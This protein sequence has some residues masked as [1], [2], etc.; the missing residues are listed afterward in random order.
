MRSALRSTVV[1]VG[2]TLAVMAAGFVG[3]CASK[4]AEPENIGVVRLELTAIPADVNCLRLTAQGARTVVQQFDVIPGTDASLL[5]TGLPTGLVTIT[6]DAFAASCATA[7]D[8][9]TANWVSEPQTLEVSSG[10]IADLSLVM[11]RNG[12]VRVGVDFKPDVAPT[13]TDGIQN[14]T[15]T[16][17]DCGGGTCPK[18]GGGQSCRTDQDCPPGQ[19]CAA[20][21][22]R[23]N[24]PTCT[25]GILNGDETDVDCGGGTC[26]KCGGGQSCRTD[27][28]CP[29]GQGCAAFTCRT[30]PPT[31]TDG[32][33][34]GDET[35]VDCGGGTCPKC[36]GGQSCRTD[37]DCPPGQGC[38]AFTCRT[39]PPTCTDGIQN[40]NET[41]VDCGGGTCPKCGGGQSC[42]TD[43]DCPA[44]QECSGGFSCRP[45]LTCAVPS[46]RRRLVERRGPLPRLDR[47]PR[48]PAVR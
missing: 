24:P 44:G 47:N 12:K 1:G 46:R 13:C 37:Q 2:L 39:N 15:E 17:V 9:T 43:Q 41:G 35:D 29:P 6:A 38:A 5:V 48:W 18:C 10:D 32:I 26:P 3:G 27:Q 23:I 45:V 33:Q 40:G 20:F 21:T 4:P 28:D 42:R 34:N 31:C 25:D 7:G 36:G 22:C 14:G 19:G 16:G 30:N 8:R 11:H